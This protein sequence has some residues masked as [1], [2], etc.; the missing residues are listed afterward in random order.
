MTIEIQ[1]EQSRP[2]DQW[3][4]EIRGGDNQ[5]VAPGPISL[6]TPDGQ[7]PGDFHVPPSYECTEGKPGHDDAVYVRRYSDRPATKTREARRVPVSRK[8]GVKVDV[9]SKIV[10][11]K[12]LGVD[13]SGME[14][15]F[16]V[17][18][19][20]LAQHIGNSFG[21]DTLNEVSQSI[22]RAARDFVTGKAKLPDSW[23]GISAP[24]APSMSAT[25]VKL[26]EA[27]KQHAQNLDS[28]TFKIV[29]G[30]LLDVAHLTVATKDAIRDNLDTIYQEL[31]S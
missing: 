2:E 14:G 29:A 13:L 16:A 18:A 8:A 4:D 22:V 12:H 15:D 21:G 3:P 30:S 7:L 10:V 25:Q 28:E 6:M 24:G 31:R 5:C 17:N 1:S 23:L 9:D 20:A 26:Q 11:V 27:L 19:L